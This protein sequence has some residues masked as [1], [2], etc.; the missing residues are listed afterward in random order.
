MRT[1]D[2]VSLPDSSG[3]GI[4]YAAIEPEQFL[5]E[6]ILM[7]FSVTK[8]LCGEHARFVFALGPRPMLEEVSRPKLICA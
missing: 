7:W 1:V 5:S 6:S 4:V 2:D 3:C 8:H